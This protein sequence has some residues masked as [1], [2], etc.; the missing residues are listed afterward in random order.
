MGPG[1]GKLG[2]LPPG[3]YHPSSSWAIFLRCHPAPSHRPQP[4]FLTS[5]HRLPRAGA[6]PHLC[7]RAGVHTS[8]PLLPSAWILLQHM[9]SQGKASLPPLVLWALYSVLEKGELRPPWAQH[10]LGCE[11]TARGGDAPQPPTR[12]P[13][14]PGWREKEWKRQGDRGNRITA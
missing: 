5:W 7:A 13:W 2:A 9:A 4:S 8:G 3:Y 6:K 11:M 12:T 10:C 1:V 14:S